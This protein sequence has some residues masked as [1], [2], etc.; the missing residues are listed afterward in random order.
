MRNEFASPLCRFGR[1]SKQVRHRPMVVGARAPCAMRC[2]WP[3]FIIIFL[4]RMLGRG[5]GG[6][7]SLRTLLRWLSCKRLTEATS[8]GLTPPPPSPVGVNC[9]VSID[10]DVGDAYLPADYH[11]PLDRSRCSHGFFYPLYCSHDLFSLFNYTRWR[12][13][14]LA[15]FGTFNLYIIENVSHSVLYYKLFLFFS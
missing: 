1:A 4:R 7:T 6:G 13:P 10:I 2:G 12:D 9:T 15:W 11:A 5:G 14:Q 3:I 8:S